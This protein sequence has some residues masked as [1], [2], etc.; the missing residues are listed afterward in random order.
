[1]FNPALE[2]GG[3]LNR[4]GNVGQWPDRQDFQFA[5]GLIGTEFVGVML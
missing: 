2:L 1:V 3:I 4:L 5:R